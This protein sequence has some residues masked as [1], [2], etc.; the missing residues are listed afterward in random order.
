MAGALYWIAQMLGGLIIGV[1]VD[2]PFLS[3]PNRARLGWAFVLI[4]GLSIWGGGYAFAK[5]QDKRIAADRIQDID[6]SEGSIS[7]G[8]IFLYIFYGMYDAFWYVT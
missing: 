5:W 2:L 4:T 8:P 1:I 7:T 3:R 6:Y